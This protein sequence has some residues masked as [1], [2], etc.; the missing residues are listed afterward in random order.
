MVGDEGIEKG[1]N[2]DETERRSQEDDQNKRGREGTACSGS[3]FPK[4]RKH[5]ESGDRKQPLPPRPPVDVPPR[6]NKRQLLWPDE[7]E[8]IEPEISARDQTSIDD[9]QVKRGALSADELALD[10][11]GE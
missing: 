9:R 5:H 11:R 6:I 7:F 4:Q 8:Q 3:Q 1:I 10:P 2:I